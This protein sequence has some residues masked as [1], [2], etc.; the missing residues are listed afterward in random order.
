MLRLCTHPDKLGKRFGRWL[1]SVGQSN[2]GKSENCCRRWRSLKIPMRVTAH[3]F[4]RGEV[5]LPPG[6]G[7]LEYSV[8]MCPPAT[9]TGRV[10]E[11]RVEI[12]RSL[13]KALQTGMLGLLVQQYAQ[14]ARGT[15]NKWKSRVVTFCTR[16][17]G[18]GHPHQ[19]PDLT[20]LAPGGQR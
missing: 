1:W 19:C 10:G 13:M 8:Q 5:W 15:G 12:V 20:C 14:A 7:P 16:R 4:S 3:E 9:R 18:K 17:D 2:R 11:W 6:G